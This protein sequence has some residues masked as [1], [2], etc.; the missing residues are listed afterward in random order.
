V[1]ELVALPPDLPRW[2]VTRSVPPAYYDHPPVAEALRRFELIV[3]AE[4]PPPE[5]GG[6]KHLPLPGGCALAPR[7]A[8]RPGAPPSLVVPP[9]LLAPRPLSRA[10]ARRE[11][12]VG[13]RPLLLA[14]GTGETDRQADLHRL[15]VRLGGRLGLETRFVSTEMGAEPGQGT[16]FRWKG[17]VPWRAESPMELFPLA[18]WLEAADVVVFHEVLASG[19]PAVFIP[20]GR[21]YDD[22]AARVRGQAVATSPEELEILVARALAGPR[23]AARDASLG[24]RIVARLVEGRMEHGVL[25]EEQIAAIACGVEPTGGEASPD[26]L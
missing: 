18:R 15:I 11:L 19:V 14:V 12:G 7:G 4:P 21:R 22:Q 2:L 5:L 9:V 13:S 6:A 17:D 3:W 24:A 26:A 8:M 25:G 10:E 20:Q 16:A 23:R 1:G